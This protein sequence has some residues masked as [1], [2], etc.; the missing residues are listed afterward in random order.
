MTLVSKAPR[1]KLHDNRRRGTLVAVVALL[2]GALVFAYPMVSNYIHQQDQDRVVVKQ[3]DSVAN[4]DEDTL[5]GAREAAI[6]YNERL[7]ES[8]TVVTDPF[9]PDA[10][11]PTDEEYESVLNLA[12]DGVMG[13]ITIP[14]IHIEMPIYHG[15]TDDVLQKG[16]GHLQETSVPIG[17][18]ST[19]AVLSGHTGLPSAKIFDNLDRLEVGDY[20]IIS[21]LGEDHAYQV[22]STEIV[23]PDETDS[24]VIQEG[25]DLCTLVT[26]TPYGV[27]T[28]RL[29]VHAERCEVPEEWLNKGE[30]AFPAGYSDQPDRALVPSVLIGLLLAA[31]IIGGYVLWSRW[32]HAHGGGESSMPRGSGPQ[33]PAPRAASGRAAPSHAGPTSRAMPANV[34]SS[35]GGGAAGVRPVMPVTRQHGGCQAQARRP[36]ASRQTQVQRPQAGRQPQAKRPQAHLRVVDGGIS[37]LGRH[38]R[39]GDAPKNGTRTRGLHF[40]DQ[41]R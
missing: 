8:R 20:F 22:T 18:A 23:L 28:H 26:C 40:R 33:G 13:T 19:H 41:D 6:A 7:K 38:A 31:L 30:A 12:G 11:R 32:R 10:E 3:A 24:L 4:T 1:N 9:D 37:S 27:N 39:R 16:V 17:G 29:L 34:P 35:H 2:F 25:K 5:Q 36:Q 14:K 21:V 15:T